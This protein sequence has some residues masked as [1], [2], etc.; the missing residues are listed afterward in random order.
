[1][2]KSKESVAKEF[3]KEK[4]RASEESRKKVRAVKEN[5]SPEEQVISIFFKYFHENSSKENFLS[6]TKS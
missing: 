1:M 2:S 3:D 4:P 5:L 6:R